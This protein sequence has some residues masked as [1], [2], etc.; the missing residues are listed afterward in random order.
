MSRADVVVVGYLALDTITCP[1][2]RFEHVA[3]GAALYCS[4]AA[5][6]AGARVALVARIGT[7]FPD[8]ALQAL[9][10]LGVSLDHVVRDAHPCPRS[11]LVDPSGAERSSPHHRD[12]VWWDAQRALAPPEPPPGAAVYVFNAM[13]AAALAGQIAARRTGDVLVMDTSAAF[14]AAEAEAIT[15]CVSKATLFAPSREETR[16]MMQDLDDTEALGRLASQIGVAVQKR[17]ADGLALRR[18]GGTEVWQPTTAATI[19]DTTGA[20]DS[21]VGALA[22]GLAAGL[23]DPNLLSLAA[24][25]AARTIGGVGASALLALRDVP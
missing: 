18:R 3:G 4:A 11:R 15:R 19:V 2:G 7:G 16:M 24:T 17:G 5:A 1:A 23:T 22:A 21:V 25:I 9:R 6:A 13:P 8:A 14:L 12:P 20:G 10:A